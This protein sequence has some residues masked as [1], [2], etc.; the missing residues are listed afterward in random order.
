[1]KAHRVWEVRARVRAD[2]EAAAALVFAEFL[3]VTPV[4]YQDEKTGSST[5]SAFTERLPTSDILALLRTGLKRVAS[6]R[7]PLRVKRL[8]RENWAE[9][10]KRHFK[11]I[12][13]GRTLLIKPSWS[14]RRS[15][16]GQAVVVLDPGLSFGTGQHA[17]TG[18][19]LR[20]IV[21]CRRP[22]KRQMLLDIGTGSGILAISAA[23]VGY[24]PVVGF[25]VDS[26]SV[27]IARSNTRRN[28]VGRRVMIFRQDLGRAS[29]RTRRPF[30]VVCANL[31]ADV[32]LQELNRITSFV[33]PGGRLVLAGVLDH[34]FPQV[35]R[36]YERRGWRLVRTR[37]EKEW[38]SGSF[39]RKS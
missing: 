32:L 10:W 31:T 6:G 11:P 19:C 29:A 4:T 39:V 34:Q 8:S 15:Q 2:E 7:T 3:A 22:E 36:Q 24:H 21:R 18:F 27:R 28:R 9:S 37:R 17:T 16:R 23:K 5:V 14:Q 1:M 30:D 12:E 35:P 20:E 33:A 13:I 26:D 38:R 25:D